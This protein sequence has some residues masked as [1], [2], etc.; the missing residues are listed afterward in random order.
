MSDFSA[1]IAKAIDPAMS[2][3]EREGVYKLVREAVLRLQ[4]R[5]GLDPADHRAAFRRHLVEETIR[6]I[7][8][9][10]ARFESLRKLDEAFAAQA[11]EHKAQSSGRR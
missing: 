10:V 4:E 8:S 5:D 7:E 9:D 2:R 3:Q 1:L 11:K 6:D